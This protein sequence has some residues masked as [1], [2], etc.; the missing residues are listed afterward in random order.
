MQGILLIDKPAGWTSFDVVNYVRKM[1][2]ANE[3]KKPKN[4]KC[5]HTGTLDPAATGLLVL[6]VGKEYTKRAP[7]LSKVDKTYEVRMR[8]GQTS[9]TGDSEGEITESSDA[10]PSKDAVTATLKHFTGDILQTP[11]IYSA[12]KVNGQRAY[13]LARAGQ[14]VVLEPRPVT[15]Y[16]I[17]FTDYTYPEVTF[18]ASVSSGTY[19]RSLVEDIGATLGTGAYMSA[20]RRSQVG[21]YTLDDAITP[22]QLNTDMLSVHLLQLS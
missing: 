7:G 9:T 12:I 6:L 19:I 5:G 2:A 22:D 21:S 1:V 11:P 8:L 3:G 18:I 17:E 14:E 16:S 4:I 13:K 15:V 20:L 10:V